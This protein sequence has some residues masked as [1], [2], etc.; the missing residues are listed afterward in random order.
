MVTLLR[1]YDEC[2]VVGKAYFMTIVYVLAADQ[3]PLR[4]RGGTK[5]RGG[6]FICPCGAM[7]P[8]LRRGDGG[9]WLNDV[10]RTLCDSEQK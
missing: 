4:W 8:D 9:V 1:R 2:C 10:L 5:C 3:V 6:L 7:D